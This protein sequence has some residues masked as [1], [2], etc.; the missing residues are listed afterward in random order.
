MYVRLSLHVGSDYYP[1]L[2]L[3]DHEQGKCTLAFFI[4]AA[5]TVP[6]AQLLKSTGFP[7]LDTAC[8][9]SVIGGP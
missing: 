4:E 9:E 2:S 3:K 1:K 5:G 7:R 8:F 6:A